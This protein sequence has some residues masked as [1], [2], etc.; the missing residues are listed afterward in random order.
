MGTEDAHKRKR[1]AEAMATPAEETGAAGMKRLFDEA[2]QRTESTLVSFCE[3]LSTK[4][5]RLWEKRLEEVKAARPR[6]TLKK[7]DRVLSPAELNP[8]PTG[9]A[10]KLEPYDDS[11]LMEQLTKAEVEAF[12]WIRVLGDIELW[13]TVHLPSYLTPVT[14]GQRIQIEVINAI[15]SFMQ[16][17][18]LNVTSMKAGYLRQKATVESS[19]IEHKYKPT[20]RRR[21]AALEHCAW[22]SMEYS[23]QELRHR[24]LILYRILA[25]CED[26]LRRPKD[27][28]SHHC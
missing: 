22:H 17:I 20:D 12:E 14:F 24:A 18:V 21:F 6:V 27:D 13:V 23:Y 11:A 5:L 3:E 8:G 9:E 2:K 7:P 26:K 4:W 15:S 19:I 1:K 16:M 25:G 10:P 28:A